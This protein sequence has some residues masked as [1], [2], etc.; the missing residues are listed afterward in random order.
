VI[1]IGALGVSAAIPV[2]RLLNPPHGANSFYRFDDGVIV[3]FEGWLIRE[4]EPADNQMTYLYVAAERAGPAAGAVADGDRPALIPIR[5]AVRVTV[6]NGQRWMIGDEVRVTGAL[7]FP[8]NDG[9]PGEFD[10]RGWLLRQG[11]GAAVFAEP[12]KRQRAPPIAL[13]GHR[14]EFPAEAIQ[15]IRERIGEFIDANLASP[16]RAELRAL[17]IGDRSAI[18]EPLRQRFAL[19]G[20]AHLLV[21]SGL[22]LGFV[23]AAA[24][25]AMRLAIGL[26]APALM[27][28][29]YANKIAA[30][31]AVS[32]VLGYSAIAGHHVSTTR[33]LVMVLSYMIALM[34]DRSRE[35]I[36]S[37]A[38][39]ALVICLAMPGSSAESLPI[40]STRV[41]TSGPLPIRVAPLT[42]G[43]SLPSSIR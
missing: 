1:A 34:I 20:M 42:A 12:R 4:P 30:M 35:L 15:R 32:A 13:I 11:I 24:F 37:L 43:P 36:A 3:T 19:T 5:G 6:I 27:V 14:E 16:E 33:A 2:G 40:I 18:D 17:I 25:F 7:R 22:H 29:G 39:A 31:A 9:D 41:S 10:Y 26:L 28:R 38:L 23:A 21:I 8:R